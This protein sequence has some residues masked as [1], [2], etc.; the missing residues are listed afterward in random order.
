MICLG[1]F[2]APRGRGRRTRSPRVHARSCSTSSACR[3]RVPAGSARSR[4]GAQSLRQAEACP[5]DRHQRVVT[6]PI[7]I[8]Q[9]LVAERDA[10]HMLADERATCSTS[11][12]SLASRKHPASRRTRSRRRSTAP[13]SRPPASDVSARHR[14]R[15]PPAGLRPV[16]TRSVLRYTP[17]DRA[18][19][20]NPRKS[21]S[22]NNFCLIWR[23]DAL[24]V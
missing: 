9:V 20:E 22:Q 17:S 16:Q 2:R 12:G 3:A 10:E 5:P 18:I 11:L 8:V 23:P 6:K 24:I 21:F 7:V 14:T 13:N 4:C 19:Q 1:D 15:R